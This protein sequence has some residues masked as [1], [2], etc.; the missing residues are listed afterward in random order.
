[1]FYG[2]FVLLSLIKWDFVFLSVEIEK[3]KIWAV[4]SRKIHVDCE[5]DSVYETWDMIFFL[6]SGMNLKFHFW[7]LVTDSLRVACNWD[8]ELP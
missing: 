7:Y 2:S 1:M 8:E 4:E 6:N 5:I 3:E